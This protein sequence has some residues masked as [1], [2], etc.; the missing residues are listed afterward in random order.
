M[1]FDYDWIADDCLYNWIASTYDLQLINDQIELLVMIT[2]TYD[3]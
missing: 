1:I 3:G 2:N